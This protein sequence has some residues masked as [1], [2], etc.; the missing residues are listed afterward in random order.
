MQFWVQ[1]VSAGLRIREIPVRLIYNDPTRSF[2]GPLDDATNRIRHY[3]CTMQT[4]I[5]RC[6]VQE[7]ARRDAEIVTVRNQRVCPND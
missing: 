7:A 6:R 2:G 1:A 4:E 5:R 3:R